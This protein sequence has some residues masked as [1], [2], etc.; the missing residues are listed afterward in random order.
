MKRAKVMGFFM[1]DIENIGYNGKTY[2]PIKIILIISNTDI[3]TMY[4]LFPI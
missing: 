2:K 3:D 1:I 4:K